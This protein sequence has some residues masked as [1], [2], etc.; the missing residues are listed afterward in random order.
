MSTVDVYSS[1]QQ[2]RD[3]HEGVPITINRRAHYSRTKAMAE[4]LVLD[5]YAV[6]R[7]PVTIF[8]VGVVY[9]A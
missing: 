5:A 7:L 3:C 2:P 9:G 1:H 4:K 6:H 8:R